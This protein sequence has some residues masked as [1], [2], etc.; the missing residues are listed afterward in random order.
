M[1]NHEKDN[2]HTHDVSFTTTKKRGTRL[3]DW[4]REMR[5]EAKRQ[6]PRAEWGV[7]LVT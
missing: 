1:Y 6:G 7:A 4:L 3:H 2:F 5:G